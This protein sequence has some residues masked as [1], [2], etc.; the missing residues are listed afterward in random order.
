MANKKDEIK[1]TTGKKPD[2]VESKHK[3][4]LNEKDL[5]GHTPLPG[6]LTKKENPEDGNIGKNNA[7]GKE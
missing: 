4:L 1:D 2:P 5:A 6:T 3:K 7:G